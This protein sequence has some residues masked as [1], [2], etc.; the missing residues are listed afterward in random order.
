MSF[1]SE[2]VYENV[3]LMSSNESFGIEVKVEM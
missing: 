3:Y 2:I 1:N